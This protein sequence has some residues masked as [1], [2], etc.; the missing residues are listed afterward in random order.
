M[1]S[2]ILQVAGILG[3]GSIIAVILGH[4][5]QQGRERAT[6]QRAAHTAWVSEQ[7]DLC[8]AL[9]DAV[10]RLKAQLAT[11]ESFHDD[12]TGRFTKKESL[13]L[14]LRDM[15]TAM[16]P[17]W[18]VRRELDLEPNT[19]LQAAIDR[20]GDAAIAYQQAIER[21]LVSLW[22]PLQIYVGKVPKAE[23][24]KLAQEYAQRTA[25][26]Q[27]AVRA[28]MARIQQPALT[29]RRWWSLSRW[30]PFPQKLS[31]PFATIAENDTPGMRHE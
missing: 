8:L 11:F 25:E 22:N 6:E 3:I 27:E 7:R 9:L 26:L 12:R 1:P 18:K 2:W 13:K 28:Y 16:E 14:A 17:I 19:Q 24:S 21:A 4:K 15:Q 20:F 31:Q 30:R 5:L 10:N 23:Q 29:H